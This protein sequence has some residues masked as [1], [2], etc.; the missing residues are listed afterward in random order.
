MPYL[1]EKKYYEYDKK[2]EYP[3]GQFRVEENPAEKSTLIYVDMR[4]EP[5]TGLTLETKSRNFSRSTHVQIPVSRG[6]RSEWV[7]VAQGTLLCM[8]FDGN[9]NESLG[10][11]FP[12]Q[13][14]SQY[15]IVIRNADNPPLKILG[16][17]ADGNVY[18][19]VFLAA[20]NETYRL[21]YGSDDI[22]PPNYDAAAVLAPLRQGRKGRRSPSRRRIHQPHHDFSAAQ[23]QNI[24]NNPWLL[25]GGVVLLVAV[26]A[27]ALFRA[28]RRIDKIPNEIAP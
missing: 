2:E 9:R 4:R 21:C 24:V 25:G 27:W 10:V 22:D 8:K 16:V 18:R 20:E 23:L 3:T 14:E 19:A 15:R 11:S 28:A 7:D 13:R 5:L 26:L 6:G 1:M 17:K 12:E